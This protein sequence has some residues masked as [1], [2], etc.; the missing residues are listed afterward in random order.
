ML[1]KDKHLQQ[2]IGKEIEI[3]LFKKDENGKKEYIGI[4]EKFDDNNITVN[5]GDNVINI[6]R[7][8]IAHIKTIY[9]W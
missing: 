6:E 3:K 9:N 4:L 1:K 2:N 5:I 7:K 8:D